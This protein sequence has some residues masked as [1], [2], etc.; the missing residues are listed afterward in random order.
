MRDP[1]FYHAWRGGSSRNRGRPGETPLQTTTLTIGKLPGP[2]IHR[3]SVPGWRMP[4][5][6]PLRPFGVGVIQGS[7]RDTDAFVM[8]N[9]IDNSKTA[10]PCSGEAVTEKLYINRRLRSYQPEAPARESIP[11]LPSL[12]LASLAGAS[13]WYGNLIHST[14]A[15]G[16]RKAPRSVADCSRPT[17]RTPQGSTSNQASEPVLAW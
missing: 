1:G 3:L 14:D 4:A 15:S 13:G 11:R 12:A 5:E 8:D 17:E 2:R 10:L 9:D 6:L 16:Q 7:T